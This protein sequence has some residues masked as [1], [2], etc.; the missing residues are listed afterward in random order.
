MSNSF[1]SA[2]AAKS[3][4]ARADRGCALPCDATEPN[5]A[6][7][8]SL[9]VLAAF[10]LALLSRCVEGGTEPGYEP[11]EAIGP[12]LPEG[13][14]VGPDGVIVIERGLL[15]GGIVLDDEDWEDL[16]QMRMFRCR[17]LRGCF[18]TIRTCKVSGSL[19]LHSLNGTCGRGVALGKFKD[20]VEAHEHEHQNSLNACI[21]TV[22]AD[23][24]LAA[25]E[26]IVGYEPGD[27]E[28]KATELWT[29]GVHAALMDAAETNQK[30][31]WSNDIWTWRPDPGPWRYGPV[32]LWPHGGKRGCPPITE[33]TGER[34]TDDEN[35][36][37]D[38]GRPG[39]PGL[40][41]SG[42]PGGRAG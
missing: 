14:S 21:G 25:V 11:P 28:R 37:D 6:P 24:G 8:F 42:D 38:G 23:G 35:L 17:S 32:L 12:E 20:L 4:H 40:A 16:A 13:V 39:G 2:R 36:P 3:P 1:G 7:V 41:A 26:A 31:Q 19:N 29:N 27:A 10:P 34:E 9:A 18:F 30:N 33:T 22:N 5:P 15:A